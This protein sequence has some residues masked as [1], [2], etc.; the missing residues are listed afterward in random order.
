MTA[1]AI[2]QILCPML[3]GAKLQTVKEYPNN[4]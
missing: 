3:Y 1:D 4:T 2:F